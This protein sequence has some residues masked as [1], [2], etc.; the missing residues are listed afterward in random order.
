MTAGIEFFR[1]LLVNPKVLFK[2]YGT[3]NVAIEIDSLCVLEGQFPPRALGLVVE[4]AS[5]HQGELLHNWKL[6]K[7]N[8][9][10]K[11]IAPLT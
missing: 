1:S 7:N 10:I 6:A 11:K 3:S 4:W 8:R 2:R 9:P 5:Q